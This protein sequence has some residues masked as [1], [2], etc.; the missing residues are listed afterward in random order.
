M[1]LLG[2]LL[3]LSY[4][5]HSDKSDSV[6]LLSNLFPAAIAGYN[7]FLEG[8]RYRRGQPAVA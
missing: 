7:L 3:L 4:F 1:S 5:T 2:C 8:R 6:G